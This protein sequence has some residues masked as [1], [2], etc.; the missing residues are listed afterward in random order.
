M[1]F[2]PMGIEGAFLSEPFR[3]KDSRGFFQE[4]FKFS[5]LQSQ[6]GIDFKVHQVNQSSSCKG[7]IRGIHYDLSPQGQA[8]YVMCTR[9]RVW[10]VV[11][12][13][14]V[15]SST[16]GQWDSAELSAD[17]GEA[18]LISEGL[19]HAFLALEDD[20]MVTYL[21][22]TEYN[23]ETEFQINALDSQLKI[24]FGLIAQQGG[25]Q[26]FTLSDRDLAAPDIQWALKNGNLPKMQSYGQSSRS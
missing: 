20:S 24:S 9:G 21:C 8:K 19:G 17:N 3:H 14:R 5:Q 12:D 7:V 2:T 25:I 4:T 22:S 10:D 23:P 15:D 18:V 1:K 11:V 6:L 26:D 16:F 13:L